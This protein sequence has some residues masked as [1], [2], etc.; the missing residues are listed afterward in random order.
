MKL[1]TLLLPTVALNVGLVTGYRFGTL[2]AEQLA[3]MQTL[4]AADKLPPPGKLPFGL[5]LEE[6]MKAKA[7]SAKTPRGPEHGEVGRAAREAETK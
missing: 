4:D 1:K 6:I 2:R 3:V 5:N 7:R